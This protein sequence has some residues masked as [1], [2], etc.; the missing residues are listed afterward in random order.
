MKELKIS[1]LSYLGKLND[2]FLP[3]FVTN[4]YTQVIFFL[5]SVKYYPAK[6]EKLELY[7]RIA[8]STLSFCIITSPWKN[9]IRYQ[10]KTFCHK[11]I[12]K[13]QFSSWPM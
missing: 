8:V 3:E 2:K 9:R 11:V 1:D 12:K 5:R 13:K 4:L 7:F 10:I 6:D